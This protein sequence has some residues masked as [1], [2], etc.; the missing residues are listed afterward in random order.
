[1][2]SEILIT[3]SEEISKAYEHDSNGVSNRDEP[4][5][6][7]RSLSVLLSKVKKNNN[8]T[9]S[10]MAEKIDI[11]QPYLS[12]IINGHKSPSSSTAESIRRKVSSL[13]NG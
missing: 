13:R 10:E 3:P 7:Q 5:S 6:S 2:N 12:S 8:L 4:S 9:Q 11:S 1:M